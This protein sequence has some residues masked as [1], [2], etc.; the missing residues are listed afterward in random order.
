MALEPFDKAQMH[1]F[2]LFNRFRFF[3]DRFYDR[4]FA[5]AGRL[6]L[7]TLDKDEIR[8]KRKYHQK[9]QETKASRIPIIVEHRCRFAAHPRQDEPHDKRTQIHTSVEHGIRDG[10]R[11]LIGILARYRINRR[12]IKPIR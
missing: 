12:L 3:F 11:S 5:I 2:R 7:R 6:C 1:V 8:P 10:R 4:F 9:C